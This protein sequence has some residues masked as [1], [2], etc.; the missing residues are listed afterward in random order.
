MEQRMYKAACYCRLSNDDLN[1]GM[2]VSIETQ[3]TL[4]KKYCRE[5]H[6]RIVDFYCDDGYT[7]TNFERPAF[8]RMMN[9]VRSGKVDTIIV[10][11]LSRFG[12]E[13]IMVDYYTQIYFPENNIRFISVSDNTII[14]PNSQYDIMLPLKSVLNEFYLAEISAKVRQAMDV[15]AQ[16]GEFLHPNLPYGYVKS[17][18]AKNRLIIDEETV[19]VVRK[20]FELAAY[21]GYGLIRIAD[22]LYDNKVLS[23]MALRRLRKG[24]SDIENPYGWGKQTISNLLNNEVY[25][26]KIVYG[27]TRKVNFKS[28]KVVKAD[29]ADW[30]VVDNAHEAIVTQKLWDDV[31]DRIGTKKCVNKG[32]TENIFRGLLKCDDCGATM[33]ITSPLNKRM[34]YV[35]ANSKKRMGGNP[36]C[37]THNTQYDAL[38]DA[39]LQDIKSV[40]CQ[41]NKDSK[42]FRQFV[43][44]SISEVACDAERITEEIKE[45][46]EQIDKEKKKY[47]RIYDDFYNGIIKDPEM[48]EEMASDCQNR[49]ELLLIRKETLEKELTSGRCY[50][51]DT[52]K[53]MDVLR[54]CFIIDKLDK[55]ILNKLVDKITVGEKTRTADGTTVQ[56]V[57]IFYRF[58]GNF[59]DND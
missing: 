4:E 53:F 40:L 37:T 3:I 50:A 51:E 45:L 8:K 2:S 9:D 28:K 44:D 59:C 23:P 49:K 22:Y 10:K 35:C 58:V 31:Q 38:Y 15:K 32:V 19:P 5:N 25:L 1:D 48:F 56:K 54:E 16:N 34:F 57:K 7:G 52:D 47:K 30:I 27:K 6:I 20:I 18:E 43:L 33:R 41:F 42:S 55:G 26:G 13:H 29:K 11:D 24:E 14:T 17:K 12:R 46:D 39:V 21:E 36:F